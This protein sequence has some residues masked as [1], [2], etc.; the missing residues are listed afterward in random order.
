MKII[1][2][3]KYMPLVFVLLAAAAAA[4]ICM[5]GNDSFTDSTFVFSNAGR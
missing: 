3:M 4:F 5:G 2:C 1:R